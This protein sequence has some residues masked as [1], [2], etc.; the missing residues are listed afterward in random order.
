MVVGVAA[1]GRVDWPFAVRF[2]DAPAGV[3]TCGLPALAP[4]VI[5]MATK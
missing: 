3:G 5:F 4:A 1:V 2:G